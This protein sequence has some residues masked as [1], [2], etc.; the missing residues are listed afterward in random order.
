ME[1]SA[2]GLR[3][4]CAIGAD[5]EPEEGDDYGEQTGPDEDDGGRLAGSAH[6]TLEERVEVEEDPQAEEHATDELAPL[7]DLA[8][9]GA[10]DAHGDGNHVGEA[11]GDRGDHKRRPLHEVEISVDVVFVLS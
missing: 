10:G 3:C 2:A 5:V 7:G 8:V 6:E 9:D 1:A 4:D 11:D